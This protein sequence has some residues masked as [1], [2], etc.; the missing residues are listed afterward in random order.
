MPTQKE[1]RE[2]L[3]TV[4]PEDFDKPF[5]DAVVESAPKTIVLP[6]T[7]NVGATASLVHELEAA[8]LDVS[9]FIS[10]LLDR[11]FCGDWGDLDKFDKLCNDAA[12]ISGDRILSRYNGEPCDVYVITDGATDDGRRLT[13]TVMRPEDY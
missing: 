12:L 6:V 2:L 5:I 3:E 4:F 13:T 11:L 7:P 9:D 1:I 10:T 8:G